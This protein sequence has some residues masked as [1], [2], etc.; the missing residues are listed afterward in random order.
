MNEI[1]TTPWHLTAPS[2]EEIG[3]AASRIRGVLVKTPLLES[4]RLNARLG[5]RLLVKAEGLQRTGSFKARG[6][7]NRLSLLSAE[8]RARGVVAFS[9]GNHAQAV[10][11]T[12]RRLGIGTV[13]IAMPADAPAAKIERTRGWGAE[14]VLY[15]RATEDRETL[16]HRLAEERN[17]ILVPP[18]DDRRVI[19]GAGT[20]GLEV[21][22]QAAAM[23]ATPEAL[24]VCCAGGGLTAG[25]A[26]A[27]ETVLPGARVFAVEPEG[28]DDTTRSLAAGKRLGNAPGTTS[29]CDAV[30]APMPGALTFSI[31]A[32]R[33]GG[34]LVVSDAEALAA[35]RVALEEFGLVVEPGGAVALA[36]AL[37]E[38]LPIAGHTVAV[39]LT[40]ANVDPG[41]YQRALFLST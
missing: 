8:E 18:Y 3:E 36:A 40:G 38:R 13:V 9:S 7:W 10:A 16:G 15:D 17:L 34:G 2:F 12:G 30:L 32:P 25:C 31:N 1:V 4:E 6:A 27:L 24:L 37:S 41:I 35:M 33:L 26:L 39:A 5:G 20:L 29:I 11:W 21:A 28:F 23:G 22:Q 14:V 19:A